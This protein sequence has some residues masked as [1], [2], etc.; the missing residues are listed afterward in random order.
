MQKCPEWTAEEPS[1][2]LHSTSPGSPRINLVTE[3]N[4]FEVQ[5]S[6]YLSKGSFR[7]ISCHCTKHVQLLRIWDMCCPNQPSK[8]IF[9]K[10]TGRVA[11]VISAERG[12]CVTVV[13]HHECQWCGVPHFLMFPRK[14]MKPEL[15]YGYPSEI[16]GQVH[17]KSSWQSFMLYLIY[18]VDH[19]KPFMDP[20]VLF[21][22]DNH[23]L[24]ILYSL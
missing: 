2:T 24:K 12:E 9:S 18:F 4:R 15:L 14:V 5:L 3:F 17:D 16:A 22:V 23:Y 7:E 1:C 6:L 21:F 19:T 11:E 20:S 8:I 10:G 13:C